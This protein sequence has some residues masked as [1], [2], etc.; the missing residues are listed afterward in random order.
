MC[1]L[2]HSGY[3]SLLSRRIKAFVSSSA[4]DPEAQFAKF[5][6]R[7]G[8]EQ[9][10]L[11]VE[12]DKG[13]QLAKS[14]VQLPCRIV[15]LSTLLSWFDAALRRSRERRRAR[16]ESECTSGTTGGV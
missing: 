15:M 8:L 10:E 2:N 16:F 5:H 7:S 6:E 11:N 3:F 12:G 14:T 13:K 1:R 4:I 9:K